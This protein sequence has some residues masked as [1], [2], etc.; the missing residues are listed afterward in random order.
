MKAD[1]K[2]NKLQYGM[3]V[4]RNAE[5][6][7]L[8]ECIDLVH[9]RTGMSRIRCFREMMYCLKKFGSGYYDYVIFHFYELSDELRETYMTRLKNKKFTNLVNDAAYEHYFDNKCEFAEVFKDFTGRSSL[10]V[11]ASSKEEIIEYF[12]QHDEIFGKI[13]DSEC[14]HGAELMKKRDFKSG[15]EFYDFIK[16]KNL[17]IIEDVITNHHVIKDI[18]PYALNTMRMV[19]LIGDDGKPHLI[20]AAQKFGDRGRFIDIYGMHGP[21]ELDTGEIKFPLHSG[22][23]TKDLFY[24]EHPYTGKNFMGLKIPYFE[25]AKKMILE[26]A[27]VIPQVRYVGWDVAVTE[28]GPLIIEGNPYGAYEY[29]QLP[30]QSED[31]KGILERIQKVVP[32]F[33]YR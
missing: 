5:L 16:E 14:G 15:E 3:R 18:Y 10:D 22:E 11:E 23:T 33:K 8:R 24:T 21:I 4:L 29:M 6:K 9:E 26:A 31:G 27:M 13:T 17:G 30:G 28:N 1:V 2:E 12:N 25:E 20:Y 32:S 19:T 7:K